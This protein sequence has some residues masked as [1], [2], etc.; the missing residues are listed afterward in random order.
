MKLSDTLSTVW[1]PRVLAL[2][3]IASGFLFM[4]HGLQKILGFPVPMADPVAL[5][6]VSGVA[7]IME[8]VGGALL[9]VG[10]FTRPVAFL[11]SG[12]MAVAY[13][14]AHAPDG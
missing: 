11:L 5:L 14:I 8:L 10:L 2:L 12:E 4:S 7:G 6:S 3:R 9:L 1:V 13:F